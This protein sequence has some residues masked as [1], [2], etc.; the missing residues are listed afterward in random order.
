MIHF[1][2][3]L[4][5]AYR[6]SDFPVC[7]R[8]AALVPEMFFL[9]DDSIEQV[10]QLLVST[11]STHI[12]PWYEEKDLENR[13]V[14]TLTVRHGSLVMMQLLFMRTGTVPRSDGKPGVWC[15]RC[16]RFTYNLRHVRLKIVKSA[17]PYP[18]GE[19]LQRER[20][21]D[22]ET[23]L[24]ELEHE[25]YE[26]NTRY[27]TGGHDLIW[28]RSLRKDIDHPQEGKFWCLK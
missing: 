12:R 26:L 21:V 20:Y 14:A 24:N 11:W 15:N 6:L 3:T 19:P 27:N 10:Q 23:R 1:F 22:G 2:K 18:N 8:Y 17:C 4:V 25:L 5:V 28:N 16:G 7:F 13:G 9:S